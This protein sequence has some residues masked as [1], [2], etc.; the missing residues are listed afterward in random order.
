MNS[1]RS[2][3]LLDQFLIRADQALRTASQATP[4]GTRPSPAADMAPAHLEADAARHSAGLM[5]VNHTGEVCAQALYRG[6]ALTARLDA[7]RDKMETASAEEA[8]HLD[9][10]QQRLEQLDSRP[11]ILNP[12]FYAA[13]FA[14]GAL[15]GLA[16]DKWSL[17]FVAE[18]ERQVCKH[19]DSHLA[20]LSGADKPS[21]AV[22]EQM[23][24]DE[25]QHALHAQEAGGAELPLPVRTAMTLVSK[26]MT[27]TTYHI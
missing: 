15:A 9:W 10:C 26:I 21:R 14:T 5:R 16:G 27:R 3:T 6:Q 17:G 4:T 22:L 18:T 23:K 25:E 12:V 8:D 24:A 13:S 20:E 2:L 7:V 19:L 11:S 1:K